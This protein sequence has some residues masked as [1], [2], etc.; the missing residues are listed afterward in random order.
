[1]PRKVLETFS[2]EYLQILDENGKVDKS[3]AP[4]L[5]PAELRRIYQV[6]LASRL[7]DRRMYH[8][9]QQGRIGTFPGV[10]GQEACLGSTAAL[11]SEDWLVPSFRETACV[12][13]RG[14]P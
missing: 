7:L 13:W 12:L 11:Q 1:M 9:Q 3:L 14:M 4:P 5:A 2:V 6:M 10:Q 8:L